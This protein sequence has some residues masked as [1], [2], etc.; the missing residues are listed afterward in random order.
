MITIH[1]KAVPDYAETHFLKIRTNQSLLLWEKGDRD[2]G[3]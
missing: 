1:K 3:G 2:S